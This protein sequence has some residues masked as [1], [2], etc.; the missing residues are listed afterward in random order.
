MRC[1]GDVITLRDGI[2][3]GTD[4]LGTADTR[5]NTAMLTDPLGADGDKPRVDG[6][7]TGVPVGPGMGLRGPRFLAVTPPI[8][9]RDTGLLSQHTQTNTE[10]Q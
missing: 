4:G 6:R 7:F 3:N 8:V 10:F 2:L 5:G 9:C 1:D